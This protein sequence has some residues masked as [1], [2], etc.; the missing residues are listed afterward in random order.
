MPTRQAEA[1]LK[2]SL[3]RA[4]RAQRELLVAEQLI[5]RAR[6]ADPTLINNADVAF[7]LDTFREARLVQIEAGKSAVQAVIDEE[8]PQES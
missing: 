1:F 2:I 4:T 5:E 6:A 3:I 8:E 7:A